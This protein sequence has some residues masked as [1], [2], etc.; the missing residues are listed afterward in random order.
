M[1]T[2]TPETIEQ[3]FEQYGW[4]YERLEP[5]FWRTGF[6]GKHNNFRIIFQMTQHW[7]YVAIAPYIRAPLAE[8]LENRAPR[9][10]YYLLRLNQ[11]MNMV[12]FSVDEDGD[13]RLAAELPIENL[14]Y[15]E[16]ADAINLVAGYA[17]DYYVEVLNLAHGNPTAATR[18][19]SQQQSPNGT[20]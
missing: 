16:F 3:Y 13:V 2:A 9:L 4:N 8:E 20:R 12:K 5:N 17:D 19:P 14:D 6:R 7:L 11:D 10:Y 18:Y 15:S 1:P